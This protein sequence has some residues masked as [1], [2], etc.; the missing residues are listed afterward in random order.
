MT[1]GGRLPPIASGKLFPVSRLWERA[2]DWLRAQLAAGPRPAA[3]LITAAIKAGYPER[4][5]NRAKVDAGFRAKQVGKE[6]I[7]VWLWYDPAVTPAAPQT[8]SDIQP[9][10]GEASSFA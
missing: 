4:T 8:C 2:A 5:L 6:G 7:N 1:S 10:K 9:V 3:D